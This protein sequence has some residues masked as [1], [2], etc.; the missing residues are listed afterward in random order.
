MNTL[1]CGCKCVDVPVRLLHCISCVSVSSSELTDA[2]VSVVCVSPGSVTDRVLQERLTSFPQV[3]YTLLMGSVS[4]LHDNFLSRP[5]CQVYPETSER[6]VLMD[7][8]L[9]A[10]CRN[11][12]WTKKLNV[13]LTVTLTMQ[14]S[15]GGK[16]Q[17]SQD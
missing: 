1:A 15:E 17:A 10:G 13:E 16:T 14:G 9:E 8:P 7:Q 2:E 12:H 11:T 4:Q 3:D 6:Y 5:L